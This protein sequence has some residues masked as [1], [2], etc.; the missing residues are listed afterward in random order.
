MTRARVLAAACALLWASGA[1]LLAEWS[2]RASDEVENEDIRLSAIVGALSRKPALEMAGFSG[3]RND[4]FRY[5]LD[6]REYP[7]ACATPLMLA[8]RQAAP[9]LGAPAFTL[10]ER[11][12]AAADP[13]GERVMLGEAGQVT[14]RLHYTISTIDPGS[15]SPE[16]ADLDGTPD[17]ARLVLARLQQARASVVSTLEQNGL[18]VIAMDAVEGIRDVVVTDLPGRVAAWV[19]PG[20]QGPVLVLDRDGVLSSEGPALLRHQ[21]THLYQMALTLDESPWWYEA[22]ATWVEDPRGERAARRAASVTSYLRTAREGLEPDLLSAWEGSFLWPQFLIASGAASPRILSVAWDEMSAVP[23]NNTLAALDA[24]L[25]RGR[26][27]SLADEVRSFR[28]WNLFLGDADDGNHYPFGASLPTSIPPTY[29]TIP[30]ASPATAEISPLGGEAIRL[31]ASPG[32]GGWRMNFAG[33]AGLDWD[34]ALVTVPAALDGGPRLAAMR[35]DDQTRGMSA[36]PWRDLAAVVVL[37]QNLGGD[38]RNP[39]RYSLSAAYDPIVPF[40]L[41]AFSADAEGAAAALRWSTEREVN[42]AGWLVYRSPSPVGGFAPITPLILPAAGG[43]DAAAYQFLD[44]NVRPGRKYYYLVEGITRDG[45]T[46][47][48][49]LTAVRIPAS[50]PASQR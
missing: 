47:R 25:S 5:V 11:L 38:R 36:V 44:T 32:P 35:L 29:P 39:A 50:E 9:A 2:P 1:P 23:G 7:G 33:T 26:G 41:M 17:Q 37:V 8:L 4:A 13:A 30:S 24:A 34:V 46:S 19:Y 28:I 15:L 42:L 27:T 48:S 31:I 49:H 18:P 6:G 16:D 20:R 43:I 14:F 3:D 40:D 10:L 45:F 12:G 22:H 21:M